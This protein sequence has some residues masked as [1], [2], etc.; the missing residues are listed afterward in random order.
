MS[1]LGQV[2]SSIRVGRS[3]GELEFQGTSE[4]CLKYRFRKSGGSAAMP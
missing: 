3:G 1:M 2:V 4:S